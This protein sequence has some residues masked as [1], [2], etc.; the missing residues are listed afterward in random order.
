MSETSETVVRTQ[1]AILWFDRARGEGAV[2]TDG[3]RHLRFVTAHLPFEP[4]VGELVA[5][6]LDASADHIAEQVVVRSLGGGRRETVS[7]EEITV[8]PAIGPGADLPDRIRPIGVEAP[9]VVRTDVDPAAAAG[10]RRR[11]PRRKYP[12]RRSGEAFAVGSSVVHPVWGQGF[13]EV[14]TTRVA[15]VKFAGQERQVRVSELAAYDD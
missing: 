15:R 7:V 8:E 1:G 13:V 6:E 9:K 11:G 5:V 4:R 10:P 3:R 12:E 2:E 14:S